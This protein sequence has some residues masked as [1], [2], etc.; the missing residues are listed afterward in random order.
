MALPTT[1]TIYGFERKNNNSINFGI[2]R[3]FYPIYTVY[4]RQWKQ[5]WIQPLSDT[6]WLRTCHCLWWTKLFR[7]G[8]LSVVVAIQ[9]CRPYLLG[10][11]FTVVMDHQVLKQ[12]MS[13]RDPTGRL[14]WWVLIL[15]NY[16]FTIQYRP[17]KRLQE[18]GCTITTRLHYFPATYATT[19]FD[20]GIA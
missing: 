15:Q 3:F 7:Q 11:H 9:K 2:P 12:L 19:D 17:G 1:R 8:A 13:L 6:T 10:N 14:A 18:Y 4:Q 16:H 20:S 5:Y